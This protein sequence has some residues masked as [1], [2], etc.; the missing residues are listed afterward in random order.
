MPI[1]LTSQD[2]TQG[3]SNEINCFGDSLT[4]GVGA[5]TAS[6][7]SYPAQLTNI[8][9][10]RLIQNLGLGGQTMEQIASRQGAKPIYITITSDT[11]SGASD[12]AI[13]SI[14]SQFLSWSV[15]TTG[16][17][18]GIVNGVPCVITRT[19]VSTVETYVIRG[20]NSSTA[21]I[22]PNSIFY[23][24]SA[25]NALPTIQIFWWG[26]N[27]VPSLTGLDKLIDN[28]ISIMPSPRRF[29]VIGVLPALN[30]IIGTTNYNAI[31]AMNATL[32]V[33]YPNNYIASTPPTTAEMSAIMYTPTT[34]DNID[35]AN[36]V[37]PTGMH[38]DNV[39]LNGY[40]YNIIANRVAKL[41][42]QYGW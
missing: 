8:L 31:V 41:I 4:Q 11:L 22:P 34:Q 23:P 20:Y 26:R 12:T 7:L 18:S 36:G 35:I 1:I 10:P 2:Y 27:N 19:V 30:E 39:H 5:T 13:T 9:Y 6:G 37:F 40:G 21:T 3:I 32:A 33:N 25:Y 14:S 24:D 29:L 17:A 15:T 28:A 38:N 42:N 16:Y